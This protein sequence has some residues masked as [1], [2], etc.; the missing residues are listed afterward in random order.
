MTHAL[1][2]LALVFALLT[3]GWGARPE[4]P[5][6]AAIET[7]AADGRTRRYL[8]HV[9]PGVAA[10]PRP[11]VIVLH[12][13][14]GSAGG[15][16]RLSGMDAKAD[17]AG[18]L[19]AYPEGAGWMDRHPRSWNAGACCGYAQ[20]AQTDDVAFIRAL[21][22]HVSARHPVDPRRVYATGISNGAMMAYRL[23]CELSDR[24]SAIAPVAGALSVAGCAPEEPVSVVMFHGTADRYIRYAGGPSLAADDPRAD[25]SVA[26]AVAFWVRHNGCRAEPQT[27]RRGAIERAAYGGCR[28]GS[29][30]VLYT[31][32]G[33]GH[34]W[35]G[36]AA[37]WR[38]GDR[39]TQELSAT[40]AMWD[41]FAEH[42]KSS[43]P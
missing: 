38:F 35:P 17:A 34:A 36:G 26:D 31:V 13:D 7:L 14:A 22:D 12:A 42:A 39:P 40:D 1:R 2:P 4:E 32:H 10:Q 3:V 43:A 25:P 41:L 6:G 33:G 18:F 5:A 19:V 27:A 16:R 15:A 9:P 21:I 23:A 11:L 37:G 28:Q 20:A 24:I 29:A 30:V 8:L